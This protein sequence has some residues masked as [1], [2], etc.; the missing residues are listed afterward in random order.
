MPACGSAAFPRNKARLR[1]CACRQRLAERYHRRLVALASLVE[2]LTSETGML[3]TLW[4][5]AF[6]RLGAFENSL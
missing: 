6:V 5:I 3:E 2:G 4:D 1:A